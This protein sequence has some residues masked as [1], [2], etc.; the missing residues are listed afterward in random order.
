MADIFLSYHRDDRAAAE[1]LVQLFEQAGFSVWWDELV[2]PGEGFDLTTSRALASSAVAVV[3]WSSRSVDSKWVT[4][5]AESAALQGKLL[6]VLLEEIGL[7]E[8]FA[9][10]QTANLTEWRSG[11][12]S[13]DVVVLLRGIERRTALRSGGGAS[14][15]DW[16][17]EETILAP[18]SSRPGSKDIPRRSPSSPS[19]P[20]G[21]DRTKVAASTPT[22]VTDEWQTVR[23]YLYRESE[24][25]EVA[26]D[27]E[28]LRREAAGER[29][30]GSSPGMA[31]PR[32]TRITVT[33]DLQGAEWAP[34]SHQFTW[35]GSWKKADFQ[36]RSTGGGSADG[37][38]SWFA[39]LVCI[40]QV[41]F[42]VETRVRKPYET[43]RRSLALVPGYESVFVSYSTK[44]AV[45][46]DWLESSYTALGMTY[47][48]DVKQLRAGETWDERLLELIKGAD[49]F[50]LC[51]S[52][53]AKSSPYVGEEWRFALGLNKP[54]FIRP[55]YWEDPMPEPPKELRPLHFAKLTP[56]W[57]MRVRMR[58]RRLFGW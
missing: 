1:R 26:A 36:V 49:L 47:L 19:S 57:W 23:A 37:V 41:H 33:I 9:R 54:H 2:E 20:D 13:P 51:W 27:A 42:T 48:R 25:P 4:S 28:A 3:L 14:E 39:G 7:P 53:N 56:Y 6:P 17:K 43:V 55:C 29:A 58:V 32:G 21:P 11:R 24:E 46:I 18:A 5:E 15:P 44:D 52:Q 45:I 30:L 31:L 22:V 16:P 50:Q 8:K 35:T 12:E 34:A 38:V 10:Y 40:G